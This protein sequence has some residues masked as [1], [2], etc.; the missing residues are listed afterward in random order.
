MCMSLPG[1]CGRRNRLGT[2]RKMEATVNDKERV[3]RAGKRLADDLGCPNASDICAQV[4]AT[5]REREGRR[6]P[7]AKWGQGDSEHVV[8][9]TGRWSIRRIIA[10]LAGIGLAL[11]CLWRPHY[12][13][14][15]VGGALVGWSIS[16]LWR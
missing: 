6:R 11:F 4:L 2:T 16:G 13:S 3:E 10:V 8:E 9:A 15:A 14:A 5:L 12:A 1:L 7:L